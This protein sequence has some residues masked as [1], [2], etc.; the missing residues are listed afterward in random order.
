MTGT[1][2][3][4]T[5]AETLRARDERVF[6]YRKLPTGTYLRHAAG[7][8]GRSPVALTVE[9]LRLL[10]GQ[11]RMT[12]PEYV[13]YGIYDPGLSDAERRRFITNTLHWPITHACCDMTWQATTEDSWLCARILED[14]GVPMPRTLAVVDRAAARAWP[15][16][17]VIRTAAELREFALAHVR[18]GAAVFGKENR[19]VSGFGTFLIRE[20]GATSL[21]LEGEGWFGYEHCLDTLFDDTVYILQPV[22][23]NHTFFSRWTEHLATVRICLLF[24]REGPKIPFA[25]LKLPGP[26]STSDHFWRKGALACDVDPRTGVIARARTKDPLGTTEYTD[27]PVTGARIVGET[28][29][30]WDEVLDLARAC[31]AVFAPVRYQSMDV[32]MT[33]GGPMLI[34]INTGG[35]FDL[36]QLA[37]GRGFLTGEV[38]EFF[39]ECGVR[40]RGRRA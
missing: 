40:L 13:Q 30:R 29:P 26:G 37:S 38:L 27:H 18:D 6:F 10:R 36:P 15:G 14:S 3:T 16:T 23:R 20:A 5:A 35:G 21:R 19:G 32:A 1:A 31:S 8:S 22:E 24:T 2:G 11:G 39:A 33:P 9:F 4:G 34:E 7:R 17:L 25:V 12:L 28:L